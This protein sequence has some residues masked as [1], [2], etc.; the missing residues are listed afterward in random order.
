VTREQMASFLIRVLDV[1]ARVDLL[2]D[3][4]PVCSDLGQCNVQDI[5]HGKSQTFRISHGWALLHPL[6]AEDDLLLSSPN[7]RV[8]MTLD[9]A[10]VSAKEVLVELDGVTYRHWQA[11]FAG[12][13]EG[14][15]TVLLEWYFHNVLSFSVTAVLDF[16]D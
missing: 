8:E 13:L 12:G 15:H 16:V 4:R 2:G 3:F 7:T 1:I 14:Q 9:G 11:T 10:D 6:D 5:V